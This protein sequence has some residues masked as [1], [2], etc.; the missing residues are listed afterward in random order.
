MIKNKNHIAGSEWWINSETLS[1]SSIVRQSKMPD[2]WARHDSIDFNSIK[3]L[4]TP[5]NK[6]AFKLYPRPDIL[7]INKNIVTFR[8]RT[9]AEIWVEDRGSEV[10]YAL[11]KCNQRQFYPSTNSFENKECFAATYR[12]Y[13][14]WFVNK[15]IEVSIQEI[16]DEI[17]PFCIKEK[18]LKSI[19]IERTTPYADTDFIDFK[20]KNNSNHFLKEG[21]DIIIKGTAMYDMAVSLT[22]KEIIDLKEDY[23]K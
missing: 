16:K 19:E 9:H 15:D 1:F 3:S 21:Y 20:I 12:F 22:D 6:Y 8:Q 13:I 7:K 14:P 5:V 10:L 11:D 17:T 23:G 18:K 2:D 4:L